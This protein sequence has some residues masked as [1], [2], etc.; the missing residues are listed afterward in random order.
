ML[1]GKRIL[2]TGGTGSL[3]HALVRRLLSGELGKPAKVVVFSRDE[4]KQHEMR[5][6]WH[7]PKVPTEDAAYRDYKRVLDFKIGDVRDYDSI[8][9]A[10]READ[11][12]FH[13]AALKQ[14]PSCEY[15]PL[16]AVKTNVLGAGNLVRA[17][18]APGADVEAALAISTDKACKPVNVMGMT[19]ALQERIFINGNLSHRTKFL[20]VRYGNVISS[21]GSVIPLFL[22]QIRTGGPVT[23][24]M[25][26]MTRFLLTLDRAVDT[27]FAALTSGQPGDTYIPRAPSASVM[28]IAKALIGEAKIAIEIIGVRPG[29][30]VHEILIS[31]E[32]VFRTV[33][34]GEYYVIRPVLP[35]L[36]VASPPARETEYSSSDV[37]LDVAGVRRLLAESEMVRAR[38]AVAS[39]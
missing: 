29:E 11:I 36:A 4:A 10:V 33:E 28:D 32:E 7:R 26:R 34:R 25:D 8:S 22:D 27:V 1:D 3:G 19:K 31:E 6:E 18:L 14:V 23:V 15:E 21:R 24:T 38:S 16:E 30:K 9:V 13:A 37:T 17:I 20:C 35:E 12:V 2:V 39:A 5:A